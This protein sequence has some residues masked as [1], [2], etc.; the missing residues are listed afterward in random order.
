MSEIPIKWG[1]LGCA[2]I[3]KKI[4]RAMKLSS[5]SELVAI[6]SRDIAKARRFAQQNEC[7]D[8]HPSNGLVQCY[9]SYEELLL[10][11]KV[12]AVYIP[13]PTTMHLEWVEKAA[14][15]KK[16][17]LLEK[18]VAVS[19]DEFA[20]MVTLCKQNNVMLMDGTMFMHHTR[21][22]SLLRTLFDPLTGRIKQVRCSFS[23][24]GSSES[25]LKGNIRTNASA[26]PLGALGSINGI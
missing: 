9:G 18:P 23:F 15:S 13:L 8:G 12:Q 21:T 25:F 11:E 5:N 7:Y 16:H 26:D 4:V 2:D 20:Q 24:N 22:A 14:Q 19:A 1:I 10:N 6:A 17:I 3:A